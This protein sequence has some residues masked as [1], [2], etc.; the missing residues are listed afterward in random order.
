MLAGPRMALHE[1]DAGDRTFP[2]LTWAGRG[3]P[4]FLSPRRR[5]VRE[6]ATTT[7]PQRREGGREGAHGL[8][9]RTRARTAA[10]ACPGDDRAKGRG[11]PQLPPLHARADERAGHLSGAAAPEAASR[12]AEDG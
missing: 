12:H 9:G 7:Q 6:L 5:G 8:R 3:D 2:Q 10:E 1:D 11:H 4:A